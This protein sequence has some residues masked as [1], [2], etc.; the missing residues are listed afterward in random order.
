MYNHQAA[1]PVQPNPSELGF[2]VR[3]PIMLPNEPCWLLSDFQVYT[4]A[5]K[6]A[7]SAV[8]FLL[9]D[10]TGRPVGGVDVL[11][12]WRDGLACSTTNSKGEARLK[13][14]DHY[15]P[16]E[17]HGPCCATIVDNPSTEVE[18]LGIPNGQSILCR[19]TYTLNTVCGKN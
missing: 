10:E 18:G 12:V 6:C 19:L 13:L 2:Y 4:Q 17:G 14:W 3:L 9:F 11:L 7:E 16:S 15:D 1:K 8:E 5:N